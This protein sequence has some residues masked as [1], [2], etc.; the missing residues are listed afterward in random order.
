VPDV[1]SIYD[2]AVAVELGV[3][4]LGPAADVAAAF[5]SKS[6]AKRIFQ[7]ADVATPL[8]VYD[9]YELPSLWAALSQY[10]TFYDLRSRVETPCPFT[11]H[12]GALWV[13]KF[14]SQP[15]PGA[16]PHL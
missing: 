5:G 15:D 8:G 3:P 14:H 11:V 10:V 7:E 16:H 6:G 2:V 4:I 1:P 12:V 9:I 13:L